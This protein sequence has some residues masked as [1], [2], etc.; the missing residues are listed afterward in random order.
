MYCRTLFQ[1]ISKHLTQMT[2]VHLG[3]DSCLP[4]TSIPLNPP[5]SWFCAITSSDVL[6]SF[7]HTDS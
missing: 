2:P 5:W 1:S 3:P 6:T 7:L 4:Q